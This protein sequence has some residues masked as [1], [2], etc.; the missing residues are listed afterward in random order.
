[1]SLAVARYTNLGF[2]LLTAGVLYLLVGKLATPRAARICLLLYTTNFLVFAYSRLA[3]LEVP[4]SFFLV[5]AVLLTVLAGRATTAKAYL[6]SVL[7]AI[8]FL[9][10]LLTKTTAI[11]ALPV[12]L[13]AFLALHAP[14]ARGMRG[15]LAAIFLLITTALATLYGAYV[16][17]HWPAD[18]RAFFAS[19]ITSK[20]PG[21]PLHDIA[22]GLLYSMGEARCLFYPRLAGNF[23]LYGLLPA[24]LGLAL[25]LL[26]VKRFRKGAYTLA[27]LWV[28]CYLALLAVGGTFPPRYYV[29]LA[30]PVF[31]L[32]AVLADHL[33]QRQRLAAGYIAFS[34]LALFA[35]L[36]LF[37]IASYLAA[38]HYSYQA[39]TR[40]IRRRVLTQ[41]GANTLILGTPADSLSLST[42]LRGMNDQLGAGSLQ[43][44][45]ARYH[46]GY[47]LELGSYPSRRAVLAQQYRLVPLARYTVM[48]NYY[49]GWPVYL[50][51]LEGI[52]R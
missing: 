1:M 42:R 49:H 23:F 39:M 9:L 6:C 3:L 27:V 31:M 36:Q 18:V 17:Q 12:I 48:G 43:E 24:L 4:M 7:A 22:C 52:G 2:F 41:P 15:R 5:L 40:D 25:L 28:C 8:V 50:Y 44:K 14:D 46:P 20:S 29:H 10:A 38:P 51:R 11:F 32:L 33:L 26:I 19:N 47:Y 21:H 35:G 30:I 45:I 13:Y 16:L 34:A 37:L